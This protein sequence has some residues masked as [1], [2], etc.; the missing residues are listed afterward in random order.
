MKNHSG[1]M[2]EA[3]QIDSHRFLRLVHR[4][5]RLLSTEK[6]SSGKLQIT[7]SLVRMPPS[8]EAT[9]VGDI[10]GALES[11]NHI[12]TETRFVE[13][14][15]SG[16]EAYL[17]FLGD[18]GDRGPY[19]PEV[20]YVV[21]SL[22]EMF[23]PNIVLLQGNHEGPEDL[24][25]HP[26]DL[27]YHLQRK[28]SVE[29]RVV[30]GELSRLYRRFYTAVLVKRRCVMLHGGV[31]SRAKNLEDIAYAHSRHPAESHLEELLW[32]DP[33]ENVTGTQPSP[34]GA[35]YLFGEG[36]TDAFL[37]MLDARFVVR[38]HEPANDGYRISHSGKVL[39]LFSRKGSPYFNRHGA[40]L[41]F[42]LS[43]VFDSAW[44]LEQFIRKL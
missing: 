42:D 27:P 23:P 24:L 5:N 2:D 17:I 4:V 21:L 34:R 43:N 18:Y 20:Y 16:K 7:G 11:L 22:K 13:K 39:T 8:G 37:R 3:A 28:F 35:G 36:V 1:L 15:S 38:G 30:Y 40:Y 19:S 10:H 9:V 41:S 14:A 32:S 26:H 12:L 31:P 29:C 33:A 44:K 25:P 6:K